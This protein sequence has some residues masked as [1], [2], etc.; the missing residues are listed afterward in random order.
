MGSRLQ[1]SGLNGGQCTSGLFSGRRI[2]KGARHWGRGDDADGGIGYQREH[3]HAHPHIPRSVLT[4]AVRRWAAVVTSGPP[5]G[6]GLAPMR[7]WRSTDH[8]A[9]DVQ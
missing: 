1:S 7:G 6:S 4:M 3:V 9:W 5:R 8:D 2:L